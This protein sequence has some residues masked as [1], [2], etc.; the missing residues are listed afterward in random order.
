MYRNGPNSGVI[1]ED[2]TMT[3][4]DYQLW[5]PSELTT[6]DVGDMQYFSADGVLF[7][8]ALE[9]NDSV[10]RS[11]DSECKEPF[12]AD[13][14]IDSCMNQNRESTDTPNG[15][16]VSQEGSDDGQNIR[17]YQLKI[18]LPSDPASVL[19]SLS[20]MLDSAGGVD[21]KDKVFV[22]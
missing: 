9:Y 13:D 12:N 1:Q 7:E 19:R 16:S 20:T 5:S 2:V 6:N 17:D 8:N 14:I 3:R 15:G 18:E 11:I 4:S 21:S 22:K 10:L